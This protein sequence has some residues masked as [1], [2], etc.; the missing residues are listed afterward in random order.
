MAPTPDGIIE[1]MGEP[2]D[3]PT[4]TLV[5]RGSWPVHVYRLGAEASDD[6][7]ATTT[8]EERLA[9]MEPLALEAFALA[10]RSCPAYRRAESPACLRRLGE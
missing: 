9:M 7:S 6:L 10:G 2:V 4:P 3:A 1:P 5:D 8:P